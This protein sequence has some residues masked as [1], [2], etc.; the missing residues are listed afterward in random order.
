MNK[1]LIKSKSDPGKRQRKYM[2]K[3]MTLCVTLS[4]E[5]DQDIIEWLDRQN[6]RSEEVRRVL[7]QE[8]EYGRTQSE[9]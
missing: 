7:R 6:N 4:K 2:R 8:A 9:H 5:K 3:H 1:K